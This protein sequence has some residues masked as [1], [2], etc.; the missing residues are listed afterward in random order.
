MSK[1]YFHP[2]TDFFN[3]YK[4]TPPETVSHGT[5]DDISKKVTKLECRNWRLE[6]NRLIADTDMGP[7]V[8]IIPSNFIMTGVDN[9]NMPVL[10]E[11]T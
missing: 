7:L 8:N 5:E 2:Q 1:R 4:L 6:G 3:K 10:E 11:I 9:E